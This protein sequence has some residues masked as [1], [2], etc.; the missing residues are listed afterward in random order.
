MKT[1]RVF[2]AVVSIGLAFVS[3]VF[4]QQAPP[5]PSRVSSPIAGNWNGFWTSGGSGDLRVTILEKEDGTFEGTL[6][7]GGTQKFGG[8]EK[9]LRNIVLT[10]R[11]LKFTGDSQQYGPWE[12]EVTIAKDGRSMEGAGFFNGNPS[13]V[14][15]K[16]Q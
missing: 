11:R 14:S 16:K 13:G 3:S 5:V 9:R 12:V 10:G 6:V 8:D 7:A 4:A 2:I 15:L 1:Y